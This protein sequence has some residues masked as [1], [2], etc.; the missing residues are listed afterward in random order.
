MVKDILYQQGTDTS[1]FAIVALVDKSDD[2][3]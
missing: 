3:L 2:K 1:A